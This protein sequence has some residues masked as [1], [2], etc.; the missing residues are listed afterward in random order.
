MI[1]PARKPVLNGI[2][3]TVCRAIGKFPLLDADVILDEAR[4]FALTVNFSGF[5]P[6]RITEELRFGPIPSEF[7][8]HY[9]GLSATEIMHVDG[10]VRLHLW[11][12]HF[13][14]MPSTKFGAQFQAYMERAAT[15]DDS[16]HL[17]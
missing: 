15:G 1:D 10:M 8:K 13:A 6:E 14:T 16:K 17:N 4:R 7:A 2:A 11:P 3:Q 12:A 9:E 5:S